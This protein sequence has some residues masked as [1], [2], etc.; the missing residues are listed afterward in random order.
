MLDGDRHFAAR[1]AADQPYHLVDCLALHRLAIDGEDDVADLEVGARG[2]CVGD[3]RLDHHLAVLLLHLRAN[4]LELA[5][6]VSI[7]NLHIL[8]WHVDL[9]GIAN[10]VEQTVDRCPL[11]RL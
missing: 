2:G 3:Q 10:D 6:D 1:L 8:C 11:L 7:G 5:S 4:T 9:V